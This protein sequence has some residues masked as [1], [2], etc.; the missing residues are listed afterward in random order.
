MYL[1]H[2]VLTGQENAPLFLTVGFIISA[3]KRKP[4]SMHDISLSVGNTAK[5]LS[6]HLAA[7]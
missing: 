4:V 7:Y 5:M 3:E 1:K 2:A 6:L